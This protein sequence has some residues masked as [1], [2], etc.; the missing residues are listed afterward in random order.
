MFFGKVTYYGTT[1]RHYIGKLQVNTTWSCEAS[2]RFQKGKQRSK[3]DPYRHQD[4]S[5]LIL[6]ERSLQVATLRILPAPVALADLLNDVR[7]GSEG[8]VAGSKVGIGGLLCTEIPSTLMTAVYTYKICA[9]IHICIKRSINK[10]MRMYLYAYI[11]ILSVNDFAYTHRYSH[12]HS[13]IY[14][15]KNIYVCRYVYIH[16]RV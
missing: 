1:A 2:Q 4:S 16:V 6:D 10:Q 12:I 7:G 14:I 15:Y 3:A 9:Y 11:Y 13:Y 8:K 5:I